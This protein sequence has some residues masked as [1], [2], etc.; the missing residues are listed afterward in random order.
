VTILAFVAT[1]LLAG[2]AGVISVAKFGS[3]D[4]VSGPELLLPAFAAAFLGSS[5]LSD[6]RF[7]VLGTIVA[8][9]LI[10]FATNGLE[11][12]GLNVWIKPVFSGCVLIV[13]VA[14]T[15]ALRKGRGARGAT[16]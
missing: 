1:G 5:I 2:C 11:V 6:G 8:A 15:H 12:L 10:A 13:A 7:S 4:P 3:A 14:L 9:F 16:S